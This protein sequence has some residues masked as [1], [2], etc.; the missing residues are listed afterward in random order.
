MQ[1]ARNKPVHNTKKNEEK[2]LRKLQGNHMK[3]GGLS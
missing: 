1:I 2:Y 3:Q